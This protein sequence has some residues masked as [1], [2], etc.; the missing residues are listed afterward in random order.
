MDIIVRRATKADLPALIRLD[1]LQT[2]YHAK[3]DPKA[4][5]T[6]RELRSVF[7]KF[8]LKQL[9]RRNGRT[10]VA[11]DS[12]GVI[13]FLICEI[14]KM[15][16]VYRF[17]KVGFISTVYVDKN[18]R[19]SGTGTALLEE[20]VRWLKSKGMNRLELGVMCNNEIGMQFWEKQGFRPWWVKMWK[21]I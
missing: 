20:A 19:H 13:G 7:R 3:L 15:K 10:F 11:L 17:P 12:K 8:F 1:V 21:K 16:I 6:G 4:L 9:A 5:K 2:D 18:A 14:Q